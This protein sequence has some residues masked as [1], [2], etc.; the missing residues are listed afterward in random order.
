MYK[1]NVYWF[2]LNLA[3]FA[4]PPLQIPVYFSRCSHGLPPP[5]P[6][7]FT[8]RVK[9]NIPVSNIPVHMVPHRFLLIVGPKCTLVA[10]RAAPL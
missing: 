4:F 1:T 6:I 5:C 10:S 2:R 7:R 3:F 9:V 8:V